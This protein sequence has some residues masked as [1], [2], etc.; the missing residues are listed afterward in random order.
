MKKTFILI[1]VGIFLGF[2]A[3]FVIQNGSFSKNNN[4]VT[5][6]K[7]TTPSFKDYGLPLSDDVINCEFKV[8][9]NFVFEN[10]I[11][12]SDRANRKVYYNTSEEKTPNLIS[13]SG[14]STETPRMKGNF[15]DEPLV[16]LN[17]T[18]ES[19]TLATQNAF[20]EIFIYN[21]FKEERVATWYKSYKLADLPFS[22]LSMGY[23]Y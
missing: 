4:L 22:L 5:E 10:K 6:S 23:C 15:G 18:P 21:I 8:T 2:V 7:E 19:I 1:T 14:L 12:T 11:D 13:F 20:G 9:S 3:S 17:N 16:I